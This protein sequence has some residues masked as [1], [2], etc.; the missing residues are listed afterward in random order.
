MKTKTLLI[1]GS[2]VV[3]AIAAFAFGR[4]ALSDDELFDRGRRHDI[5]RRRFSDPVPSGRGGGE[6][7]RTDGR[8]RGDRVG[9]DCRGAAR[10]PRARRQAHRPD[11]LVARPDAGSDDARRR[12]RARQ[13]TRRRRRLEQ[14]G[15]SVGEG[16][17]AA[18]AGT[19]NSRLPLPAGLLRGQARPDAVEADR[20]A[21]LDRVRDQRPLLVLLHRER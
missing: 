6:R 18:P 13:L 9:L 1:V 12:D 7:S 8:E 19:G 14:A 15:H 2:V 5:R 4:F 16:L 20:P 3:V 11:G 10:G 17:Q 21:A